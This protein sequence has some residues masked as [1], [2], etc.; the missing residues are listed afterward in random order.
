MAPSLLHDFLRLFNSAEAGGGRGAL[1]PPPGDEGPAATRTPPAPS[2]SLSPAPPPARRPRRTSS[3]PGAPSGGLRRSLALAG[4]ALRCSRAVLYIFD[5]AR[6]MRLACVA[7]YRGGAAGAHADSAPGRAG[8]SRGAL[9][10]PP[11]A[12]PA[13]AALLA[14]DVGHTVAFAA[15]GRGGSPGAPGSGSGSGSGGEWAAYLADHSASSGIACK[16][17]H[18]GVLYG[19]VV[20][21]EGGA[22]REWSG[23]ERRF[24]A[25]FSK[26][27]SQ[28]LA[29]RPAALAT[30][31]FEERGDDE[32]EEDEYDEEE[33]EASSG[34]EAEGWS[35]SGG[36]GA[37][38]A[39]ASIAEGRERES[40]SGSE[41]VP[42]PP[43][44]ASPA[45][46][47]GSLPRRPDP[48]PSLRFRPGGGGA[49]AGP[50]R[51]RWGGALARLDGAA[52]APA[53]MEGPEA[54]PVGSPALAALAPPASLLA[55]LVEAAREREAEAGAGPGPSPPATPPGPADG[56]R[57]RWL[58]AP[59]P[60][61]AS[62]TAAE[63]AGRRQRRAARSPRRGSLRTQRWTRRPVAAAA[64]AALVREGAAAAQLRA[65]HRRA[66]PER[67]GGAGAGGRSRSRSGSRH[68]SRDDPSNAAA[69]PP[70]PPPLPA[71]GPPPL[72][73]IPGF[74]A[75]PCPLASPAF[76]GDPMPHLALGIDGLEILEHIGDGA[77]ADVYRGRWRTN[78]VVI[79]TIQTEEALEQ[80]R[81]E[82]AA[83][84]MLRHPSLVLFMG[85]SIQ[86]PSLFIVNEYLPGGSLVRR[87]HGPGGG[88][89][90]LRETLA[91]AHT[92]A[93]G[94]HYLRM[95]G[96]PHRDMRPANLFFDV[97]GQVKIAD[98][99]LSESVDLEG[100]LTSP[101][102]HTRY[103]APEVLTAPGAGPLR[104]AA[105][106]FDVYSFG[107]VLWECATGQVPHGALAPLEV[108]KRVARGDAALPDPSRS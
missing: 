80:F 13:V 31:L 60:G 41:A 26:R 71:P 21:L 69:A 47:S 39:M 43:H 92:V 56:P 74:P 100:E 70:R 27:L 79:R 45:A 96:Y 85:A 9:Y 64:A 76:T 3:R 25:A 94:L 53:A 2:P 52:W 102:G 51:R 107:V 32:D 30:M 49:A 81:C 22:G 67:R 82:V 23:P 65:G 72:V 108:A 77:Y 44:A 66:P 95:S 57:S 24:L 89:L 98:F 19:A 18:G 61:L 58:P 15:A 11:S 101:H 29:R 20:A 28:C 35:S 33:E 38:A 42:V 105:S 91:L 83:L 93:T 68:S 4:D 14:A 12:G 78:A 63:H 1:S 37:G 103:A 59:R 46:P 55:Q 17:W 62:E 104:D 54:S 40:E 87:I 6:S 73:G 99:G 88:P 16:L 8:A 84:H 5:T 36:E 75:G 7:E 50:G 86:P 106:R 97:D 48:S 90:P 34:A 10:A